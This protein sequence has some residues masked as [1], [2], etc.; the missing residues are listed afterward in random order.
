MNL[1]IRKV[2]AGEERALW[3]LYHDTIHHVN[4][5]DYSP[6]QLQAWAP[7]EIEMGKWIEKIQRIEPWVCVIDEQITGYADLQPDGLIDHFFVHHGYQRQG[8]G[9]R[10]F[11][12]IEEAAKV[13]GLRTLH[14]HVSITARPFFESRGFLVLLQQEV[15]IGTVV[16]TN[17]KMI[18]RLHP[19]A[20][21][22]HSRRPVD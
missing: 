1:T 20:T 19:S 8:V 3:Q 12:T 2:A 17:F 6:E 13:L 15:T 16:L 21:D 22:P 7:D 9:R 5:R 18:K 4:S 10:L 11:E 14:A